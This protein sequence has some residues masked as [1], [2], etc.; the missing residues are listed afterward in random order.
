MEYICNHDFKFTLLWKVEET[1]YD[2]SAAEDDEVFYI[3]YEDKKPAASYETP[4]YYS[5]PT[6]VIRKNGKTLHF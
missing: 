1:P 3:F 6:Q 2:G 4:Q 5:P